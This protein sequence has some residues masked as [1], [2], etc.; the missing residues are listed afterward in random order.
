ME[1]SKEKVKEN[2]EISDGIFKLT[3][4]GKFD[5]VPGQFYM[6]KAW[7]EGI[8]LPRPISIHDCR[9]NE[10][11]FLYAVVGK[12]TKKLSELKKDDEIDIMG[13]SG[14]GFDVDSIKGKVAIVTGGIGIGPMKYL[15]KEL[16]DCKVDLYCGF[17]NIDYGIDELEN[18]VES[19]NISTETGEKGYK[20]YVTDLLVPE[21]YDVVICCGPEVMMKKVVKMCNEKDVTVYASMENRMACGVGACLVCT[22]K[23]KG[24][25]KRTCK[26]GPVFSGKDLVFDD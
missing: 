12:G 22:C 18:Y 25:N 23:T 16:K 14:N 17:R 4:E 1:Y 15:I 13:P 26:D 6:L 24:G 3:V 20:G 11:E 10:I 2:I 5:T 19:I 9:D 21:K 8:V 7:E